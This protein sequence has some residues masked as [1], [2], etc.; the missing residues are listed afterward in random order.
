MNKKHFFIFLMVF[1]K[2]QAYNRAHLINFQ[3]QLTARTFPLNA[4]DFDLSGADLSNMNNLQEA[5]FE[6]ANLNDVDFSGS[7]ISSA[8]F[9]GANL[10]RAILKNCCIEGAEFDNADLSEANLFYAKICDVEFINTNFTNANLTNV[11]F[12]K[13]VVFKEAVLK[14]ANLKFAYFTDVAVHQ[15]DLT[16]SNWENTTLNN[17]FF[18]ECEFKNARYMPDFEE[19]VKLFKPKN[20]I[21][22]GH[23]NQHMQCEIVELKAE[24]KKS[25]EPD[26]KNEEVFEDFVLIPK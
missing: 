2:S 8:N 3:N 19:R 6:N 14:N 25:S 20:F 15:S 1:L 11:I 12:D 24:L 23:F 7:D 22:E 17:I 21:L 26:E 4:Q 13:G 16:D 10:H 9:N 5:N 18:Y